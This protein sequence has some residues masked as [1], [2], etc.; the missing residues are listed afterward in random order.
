M[1]QINEA[2]IKKTLE[3]AKFFQS[4]QVWPLT[5][6]LNYTG[7]LNNFKTDN[8]K[9]I[10]C[11]ILDFFTYYTEKMVDHMFIASIGNAGSRLSQIFHDWK[12]SD[13]FNRV[14]YSYIPGEIPNISDSGFNFAR[15][16]KEV[17]GIPEGRLVEYNHIPEILDRINKPTPVIL[18]DD[19]IGSGDQCSKAWNKNKFEYN[20]KTLKEFSD[21]EGHIFVYAPLIVNY[22]GFERIKKDCPSL[23]LTP[24]HILGPE[25]NLFDPNCFC[26]KGSHNLYKAGTEL[27][28]KKSSELGIPSTDGR[29]TQ[30]EKGFG[31][32]GLALKFAHGA[33]DAIPAFFYWCYDNWTPLF[34]KT[35]ER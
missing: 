21:S 33:P 27:I 30:D 19:L 26:W 29:H 31:K 22:I 18:V 4:V 13:F 25:Y 5:D 28:L 8:D 16:L 6:D 35:Y 20:K 10:A 17:I 34:T 15:K 2:I 11:L 7:W 32:Q 14:V 1:L 24:C 3:R 23:I 9:K 12:H